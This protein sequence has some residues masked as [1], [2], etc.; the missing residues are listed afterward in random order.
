MIK[1]R[2]S[3]NW[4]FLLTLPACHMDSGLLATVGPDYQPATLLIDSQWQTPSRQFIAHQGDQADLRHWWQGFQDPVL[5]RLLLAAQQQS[6]SVASAVAKIA[7][8]RSNLAGADSGFFPTIDGNLAS[9][10]SSSS[11][12]GPPFVWNQQQIGLQSNWEIDLFGVLARQA[13]A[14]QTQLESRQA[15]WHDA[16]V[17]V[18]VEVANTYLN[19]RYCQAQ[20]QLQ[21]ND[22]DASEQLAKL[23]KIAG[24]GGFQTGSEVALAEANAAASGENL[25]NQQSQCAQIL[26]SLV[27]LT[28]IPEAELQGLLALATDQ[29]AKLP[30]PPTFKIAAIPAQVLMQRPDM[31]AA[32]RDVAEA[33]AKIGVEQAKRYPRLSLSGNITPT[34]QNINGSA[35][36][37]AQTWSIG[38]TLSLPVFDAGKKAASVENAKLQ[39]QAAL[40]N[41]NYKART[42][43]K[44][45]EDALLRLDTVA[46]RLPLAQKSAAAYQKRWQNAE[47][48]YQAGLGSL[49]DLASAWRNQISANLAVKAVEQ[50]QV[51]AWIA[52]YRA[53]GG[54]WEQQ[55]AETAETAQ[56]VSQNQQNGDNR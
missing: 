28:A 8:S 56:A 15:A 54:S 20:L 47:T 9:K 40:S 1:A 35:Y 19:Y 14:A 21:G 16:R 32:E 37:L 50:E 26:K 55:T 17:A 6:A 22:A 2:E 38:P 25:L 27:V 41:F 24:S 46:R 18:A 31:A 3:L 11:F 52:L 23:L 39:Y 34:L 29:Q 48:L 12:G 5:D 4:L 45:V 42:A 49:T 7:E 53:A 33:S 51:S 13:E 44:E 43:V 36:M 30:Q 10:H